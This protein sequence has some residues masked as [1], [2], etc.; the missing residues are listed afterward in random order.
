MA[1]KLNLNRLNKKMGI[2][3][4][5]VKRHAGILIFQ[6]QEGI[7]P[8]ARRSLNIPPLINDRLLYNIPPKL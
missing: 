5:C 6:L 4:P 3:T 7:N 8:M 1:L 2:S